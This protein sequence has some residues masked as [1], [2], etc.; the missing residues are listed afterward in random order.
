M[1]Q[2]TASELSLLRQRPHSTKMWLSIYAPRTVMACQLN[3]SGI[4]H[5]ARLITYN[6]V[7]SGLFSHINSGMTMMI[8]SAPGKSDVGRIRV[9]SATSTVITVAENSHIDWADD[10]YLTV[11]NFYEIWSIFPFYTLEAGVVSWFKDYDIQYSNQNSDLGTIPNMG[12]HRAAFTGDE[13]YYSATGTLDVKD[14]ELSYEWFFEGGTPTG[15]VIE[16]PGNIAYDTPGH[17][18]SSLTTTVTGS[19]LTDVTYRHVSIY[20]RPEEGNNPPILQW[21]MNQLSGSRDTGGY[22]TRITIHQDASAVVDGALVVLFADDIYG[23][24]AQSIGGNTPENAK[25]V[26]VGYVLDG[27]IEYDYQHSTVQFDVASVTEIMKAEEGPIVSLESVQSPV[28][29][30]EIE[31]LDINKFFYHYMH[32]H[33][34]ILMTTDFQYLN[35]DY[36]FQYQDTPPGS[37]YSVIN[38]FMENS[39][40]GS[41]IADRQGKLWAEIN[42]EAIDDAANTVPS[43]MDILR[44]DWVGEPSIEERNINP[45]AYIEMGGI[46]WSGAITGT[47]QAFMGGAPGHAHGYFGGTED[48]QGLILTSQNDLNTL[49]GNIFAYQNA[50]YPNASFQLSGNYRNM[51][52]APIEKQNLTIFSEDTQRGIEFI[53]KAFYITN[54][55][56]AYNPS[57]EIMIPTISMHEITQGFAGVDV[58]IPET[59]VYNW[60]PLPEIPFPELPPFPIIPWPYFP[61]IEPWIPPWP[62]GIEDFECCVDA[63]AEANI[64]KLWVSG[65]LRS[66][67]LAESGIVPQVTGWRKF[68]VVR[69]SSHLNPTYLHVEGIIEKSEDFGATW[70]E[71]TDTDGWAM[72]VTSGFQPIAGANSRL[73]IDTGLA[74]WFTPEECLNLGSGGGFQLQ[75]DPCGMSAGDG[76]IAIEKSDVYNNATDIVGSYSVDGAWTRAEY[77]CVGIPPAAS[78]G[79]LQFLVH[80]TNAPEL[81]SGRLYATLRGLV[82]EQANIVI[83]MYLSYDFFAETPNIAGDAMGVPYI[84]PPAVGSTIELVGPTR[85]GTGGDYYFGILYWMSTVG[86]G[87]DGSADIQLQLDEL[88][89]DLDGGGTIDLAAYCKEILRV[90][91]DEMYAHNICNY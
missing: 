38:S 9:R 30:Y 65:T 75:L 44:Q 8:G 47:W 68:A 53:L 89:W 79:E 31:D 88:W 56:W 20:D 13:L 76:E 32:W 34:T 39:L 74:G 69:T 17:Y 62:P 81:P 11:I 10:L 51:D 46:A 71:T 73:V 42:V 40:V 29:W 25:I 14:R 26:F 60:P 59:P 49:T 24:T 54:I 5:E 36:L 22:S 57:T 66:D 28:D 35:T 21:E 90:R 55:S 85:T 84:A 45:L 7:T 83:R 23:D 82:N 64:T 91:I 27:S 2:I 16:T 3:D 63:Y 52:I 72:Y 41:V 80:L 18:T 15:S 4:A 12:T 1:S 48:H 77:S 67:S 61:P 50:K 43:G 33:S 19:S 37:L 6:N 58:D 87:L 78:N 70:A 86:V